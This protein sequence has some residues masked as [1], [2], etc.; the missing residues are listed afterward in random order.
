MLTRDGDAI[1]KLLTESELSLAHTNAQHE[2][3]EA[4]TQH[5]AVRVARARVLRLVR[6]FETLRL[7]SVLYKRGGAAKE[8][9]DRLRRC[10]RWTPVLR[11]EQGAR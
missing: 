6:A 4:V 2:L 5:D 11:K 3:G 10:E 1:L 9:Y 8:Q 7:A